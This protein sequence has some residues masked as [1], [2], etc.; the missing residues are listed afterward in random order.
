MHCHQLVDNRV[1]VSEY[2]SSCGIQQDKKGE[3]LHAFSSLNDEFYVI[4]ICCFS[5]LD[6]VIYL[7]SL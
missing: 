7:M 6:N 3:T 1:E 5:I 2:I 4:C